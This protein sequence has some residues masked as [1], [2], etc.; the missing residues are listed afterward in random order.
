MA[1]TDL[2]VENFKARL[3]GGG[4]RPNLFKVILSGLA[5][6]GGGRADVEKASFLCKA[7]S[8]PGSTV[9]PIPV[10]FRG[11]EI[12]LAGDRTFE[13]WTITVINELDFG[14][15]NAFEIWMDSILN[16]H[17]TN[18]GDQVPTA[19]KADMEIHQLTKD[20]DNIKSY[21]IKGAWPSAIAPITVAYDQ[22]NTIEEYDVTIEYDYWTSD[23][24][25]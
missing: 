19:Y 9:A 3:T 6:F 22:S 21:Y 17:E 16:S 2:F 25:T 23:T 10:P 15:R 8:L 18:I 24:T 14:V 7:S 5:D 4:A 20:G 12:K 11:R 13:P 1:N